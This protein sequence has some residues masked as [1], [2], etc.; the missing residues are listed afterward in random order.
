[1]LENANQ[2]SER[3]VENAKNEELKTSE[4]FIGASFNP[5]KENLDTYLQTKKSK[6]LE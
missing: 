1:V 2:Y 5:E 3:L 4:S 6:R